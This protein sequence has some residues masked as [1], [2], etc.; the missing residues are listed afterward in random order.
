ML[1]P[2]RE[3]E[4]SALIERTSA[5][6]FVGAPIIHHYHDDHSKRTWHQLSTDDKGSAGS[7]KTQTPRGCPVWNLPLIYP[8]S[9]P[10]AL[11]LFSWPPNSNNIPKVNLNF[12][13]Q[14]LSGPDVDGRN[15]VIM[16]S[17]W[18]NHIRQDSPSSLRRS[19]FGNDSD[20]TITI[21]ERDLIIAYVSPMQS[22]EDDF[23][24]MRFI[25]G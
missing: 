20:S 5:C 4:S 15:F 17:S 11:S 16:Y 19:P 12:R 21:C 3:Y 14:C 1:H 9:Q 2:I 10:F 8:P 22:K 13:V 25:V 7:S 18:Y 24:K 23:L 6:A